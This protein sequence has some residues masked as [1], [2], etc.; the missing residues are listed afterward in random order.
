MTYVVRNWR[1]TKSWGAPTFWAMSNAEYASQKARW[2][3]YGAISDAER[4]RMAQ[5]KM[6]KSLNKEAIAKKKKK[7][8]LESN[9]VGVVS[10]LM[11]VAA[12]KARKAKWL[13]SAPMAAKYKK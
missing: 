9:P 8:F 10:D 12:Q 2:A 3:T 1:L 5:N 11:S 4:A 13:G 7:K 6:G